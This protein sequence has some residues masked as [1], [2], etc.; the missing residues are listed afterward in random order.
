MYGLRFSMSDYRQQEDIINVPLYGARAY[1]QKVDND[2]R[3]A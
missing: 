2:E 1:L 3:Q